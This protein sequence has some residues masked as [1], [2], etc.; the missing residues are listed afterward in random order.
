MFDFAL[1]FG[2]AATTEHLSHDTHILPSTLYCIMVTNLFQ[3]VLNP[4]P[5]NL[6]DLGSS[7]LA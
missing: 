4:I 3:C 1:I 6:P 5:S 7:L 2:E